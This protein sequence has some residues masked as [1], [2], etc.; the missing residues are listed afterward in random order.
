L[1][2]K[3]LR[4]TRTLSRMVVSSDPQRYLEFIIGK[5]LRW[6]L[7]LKVGEVRRKWNSNWRGTDVLNY[8]L[9]PWLVPKLVMRKVERYE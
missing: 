8:D 4:I 9:E 6:I 1:C 3:M 2:R 5:F 7:G